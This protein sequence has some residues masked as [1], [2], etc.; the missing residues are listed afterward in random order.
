MKKNGFAPLIIILVIAILGVVGYFTYKNFINIPKPLSIPPPAATTVVSPQKSNPLPAGWKTYKNDKYNFEFSYPQDWVLENQDP[1]IDQYNNIPL[2]VQLANKTKD[3]TFSVWIYGSN[4]RPGSINVA[5]DSSLKTPVQLDGLES[6]AYFFPNG[7]ENYGTDC[8]VVD[9][10][11]FA[12]PI[13]KYEY[14]FYISGTG[15]AKTINLDSDY[16]NILST[17]KFTK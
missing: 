14:W 1:I 3:H 11:Y 9:C 2:R 8:S 16:L 5:L 7:Y 4:V 17:F 12:V 6:T 13:N 15:H 10:S